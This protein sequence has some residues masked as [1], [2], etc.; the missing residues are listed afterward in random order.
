L[1]LT[2]NGKVDRK[3]LTHRS[4]EPP[5]NSGQPPSDLLEQWL[6]NIWSVR[7]GRTQVARD[8][9]FFD[10][11]GGHSLVA[12]EIFTEIER[13]MG[14]ALMLATL[15]QAP[16]IELLAAVI[17]RHGWKEPAKIRMLK[18]GAGV[19][20]TYLLG[21]EPGQHLAAIS[22]N[23]HRIMVV[24]CSD[25]ASE[26][27][28][29]ADEIEAFEASSTRLVIETHKGDLPHARVLV[30]T[31]NSRGFKQVSIHHLDA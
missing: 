8:A 17:R 1:P 24:D 27:N 21:H 15:F 18:Q 9:H 31:M 26:I 6:A 13:R 29:I 4:K 20:V 3:A 22:T 23:G 30:Q 11:L 19:S 25:Y 14:V 7:L 16:T 2:P 12:F 28:R 5:A 10:Q